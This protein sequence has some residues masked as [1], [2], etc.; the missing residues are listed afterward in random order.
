VKWF[1]AQPLGLKHNGLF[2][3]IAGPN[4][5]ASRHKVLVEDGICENRWKLCFS[6]SRLAVTRRMSS[7]N[8]TVTLPGVIMLITRSAPI[9]PP[10]FPRRSM[11]RLTYGRF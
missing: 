10:V 5:K 11:I 9:P 3:I 2:A 6:D 1:L 4:C 7:A 8:P